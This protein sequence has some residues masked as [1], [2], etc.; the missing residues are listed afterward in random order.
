MQ[1]VPGINGLALVSTGF[2]LFVPI[3]SINWQVKLNEL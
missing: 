1:Q 3:K 2:K